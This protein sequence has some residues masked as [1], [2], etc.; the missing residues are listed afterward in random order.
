M[1][2]LAKIWT[3]RLRNSWTSSRTGPGPFTGGARFRTLATYQRETTLLLDTLRISSATKFIDLPV[4][5]RDVEIMWESGTIS[6]YQVKRRHQVAFLMMN[7]ISPESVSYGRFAN[8]AKN[9]AFFA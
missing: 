7:A 8:W 4:W 1:T 3:K 5:K 2:Q 9:G 6:T